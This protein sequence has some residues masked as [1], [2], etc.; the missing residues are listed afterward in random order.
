MNNVDFSTYAYSIAPHAFIVN[1][2]LAGLANDYVIVGDRCIATL[3]FKRRSAPGPVYPL[4]RFAGH[5]SNN[6]NLLNFKEL[7]KRC[8][9]H[10]LT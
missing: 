4:R 8:D 10:F 2:K 5:I 9:E 7:W 1:K 6:H 3:R